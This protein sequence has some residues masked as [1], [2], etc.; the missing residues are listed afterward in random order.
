MAPLSGIT[1]S[2]AL[3]ARFAIA[4]GGAER[5]GFDYGTI[6]S[7]AAGGDG[8]WDFLQTRIYVFISE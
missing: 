8:Q 6:S 4:P 5:R 2:G 7:D 1:L 3:Q